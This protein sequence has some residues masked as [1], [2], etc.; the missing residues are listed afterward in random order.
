LALREPFTLLLLM[1]LLLRLTAVANVV[2]LLTFPA[3]YLCIF[4]LLS[5]LE[6]FAPSPAGHTPSTVA[7]TWLRGPFAQLGNSVTAAAGGILLRRL[8][9]QLNEQGLPQIGCSFF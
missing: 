3:C 2:A 8:P 5:F 9:N 7:T 1:A 4:Y 6:E